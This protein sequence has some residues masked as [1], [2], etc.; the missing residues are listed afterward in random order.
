MY[1]NT[2]YLNNSL[3]DFRDKSRPL[4]VSSCGNYRLI[5]QPKMPTW[6]PKGRLDYQLL[7]IASGKGYFYFD[8]K[9]EIVPAGHMVLYRPREVQKYVYYGS[10][11]TEVYW[12]HFTGSDVKQI[13]KEYHLPA[14]DHVIYTG[15]SPE[16]HSIFKEMIKELQLC[17]PHYEEMLA[18]KLKQLFILIDRQIPE[19][20]GKKFNLYL[21]SEIEAATR[22]FSENYA[23]NIN[24]D[25]YAA[26]RHISAC[27]FIRTFKQYNG[28]TPL[29]YILSLRIANA[30]NLL[31][32]TSCNIAEI[33]ALIGFD[34]PLYFSRFFK[35]HTGMSPTE[36]R[37]H[38]G[39][40]IS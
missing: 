7:Y 6:R 32:T 27:W 9:E 14:A 39:E 31:D 22:H 25:E 11:Q 24:I 13:L 10:D 28:I 12:V 34:N 36:Y 19:K 3:V 26:S 20:R 29:Q 30:K 15:N 5:S 2:G 17:R 16:F 8:G 37:N 38:K 33:A 1:I 23:K 18:M 4:I 35:K 40:S 21:Q